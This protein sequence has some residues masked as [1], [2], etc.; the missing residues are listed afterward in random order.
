MELLT[1]YEEA[2]KV[3]EQGVFKLEHEAY[4]KLRRSRAKNKGKDTSE[5]TWF[6]SYC[7]EITG[8]HSIEDI[9]SGKRAQD[10]FE[11]SK[12]GTKEKVDDIVSRTQ[13]SLGARM[14][15]A[16]VS[17]ELEEV[18]QVLR[19]EIHNRVLKDEAEQARVDAMSP[20]ERQQNIEELLGELRGPGFIEL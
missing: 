14:P 6:I 17:A 9:F 10:E 4:K 1:S 16:Y 8:D 20:E 5:L 15:G 3:S 7:E 11:K 13:A 18:P 19:D 12:R 2:E